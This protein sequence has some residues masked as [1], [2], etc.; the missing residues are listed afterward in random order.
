[1]HLRCYLRR[2]LKESPKTTGEMK[3]KAPE[4]TVASETYGHSKPYKH[5]LTHNQ[6]NTIPH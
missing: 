6:V 3:T 5:R 2:D 1:M 4:E